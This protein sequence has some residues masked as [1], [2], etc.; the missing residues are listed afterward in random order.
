MLGPSRNT[1]ALYSNVDTSVLSQDEAFAVTGFWADGLIF[2]DRRFG[3]TC[4]SL[5]QG[6]TA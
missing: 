5:V 6:P 1:A 3:T 2:D 4:R